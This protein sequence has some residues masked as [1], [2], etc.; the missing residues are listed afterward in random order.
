MENNFHDPGAVVTSGLASTCTFVHL[1]NVGGG[2][3]ANAVTAGQ[4][5]G[6][7]TT[8]PMAFT[9][10]TAATGS[11]DAAFVMKA[12]ANLDTTSAHNDSILKLQRNNGTD[13]F[14][15]HSSGLMRV[16][17]GQ[18]NGQ[19]GFY[20]TTPTG[21]KVLFRIAGGSG[22]QVQLIADS[23][24]TTVF[25]I[26]LGV[27]GTKPVTNIGPDLDEFQVNDNG[28]IVKS[29][30][31]LRVGQTTN[32]NSSRLVSNG[33]VESASGGFRFPDGTV[34][35]SAAPWSTARRPTTAHALDLEFDSSTLPAAWTL[36]PFGVA[37]GIDPY[38]QFST[39]NTFRYSING[40]RPG[41]FMAQ[42]S[43]EAVYYYALTASYAAPTNVFVWSRMSYLMK[44]GA[45][46]TTN[47][48]AGVALVLYKAS[49]PANNQV[50]LFFN[51]SDAGVGHEIDFQRWD[52]GSFAGT[53]H[54]TTT[55]N[56][57]PYECVGIQKLGT[58]YHAWAMT[59]GGMWLHIGSTTATFTVDSV[60]I[61]IADAGTGAPGN[62]ILGV[63]FIRF[64]ES[65]TQLP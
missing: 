49:D 51:E 22:E 16:A 54:G 38:A 31:D 26:G 30:L 14:T 42:P 2:F 63:D 15:F 56:P 35:G 41:W 13:S 64:I 59:S 36:S 11:A 9:S 20:F 25:N 28:V 50:T 55:T 19:P 47:N 43:N 44:K 45:P 8:G 1:G 48:Q 29:G 21:G 5:T 61:R 34:Q 6:N 58:T 62:A 10:N 65:A 46:G 18:N 17:A 24:N 23:A 3:T 53:V 40:Y 33:V 32:A 37:T 60:G 4:F 57:I 7:V 12:V 39:A 27:G 52:A